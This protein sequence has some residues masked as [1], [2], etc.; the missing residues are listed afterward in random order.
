MN[1]TADRD[2]HLIVRYLDGN[3]TEEETA[4]LLDWLKA[5]QDNM[6]LYTTIRDIWETTGVNKEKD[7]EAKLALFELRK[8]ELPGSIKAGKLRWLRN[9]MLW[10]IA[11]SIV[12][13]LSTSFLMNLLYLSLKND[14]QI[15][16][17]EAI[18]PLGQKGQL[19]LADGTKVWLNSGSTLRYPTDFSEGKR[20]VYLQGEAYFDVTHK[21][22][23]PFMVHTGNIL[24]K[25]L[26]TS[27]NVKS[28][29]GEDKVE[30]TLIKG[31]VKLYCNKDKAKK[32]IA[33][34][35]PNQQATFDKESK[36]T[37]VVALNYEKSNKPDRV[38]S[39]RK[40]SNE[41][42]GL[43]PV[44]PHIES[45]IQWKD[46]KLVFENET[47]AD[48]V[49]RLERWYGKTLII[50]DESLKQDRYSGKFEYNESIYQV[51]DV[52]CHSSPDLLYFE[53]DHIL[54]IHSK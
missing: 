21:V 34:L 29:P 7:I 50:E 51:L 10:R 46:Q 33:T 42:S 17:N 25:V 20:N 52:I 19:I 2:Y 9:R 23:N 41:F 5:N 6:H 47:L 37:E 24:V 8:R 4:Q 1:F 53:K 28:Y 31:S 3:T 40:P 35:K 14:A 13:V 15:V 43:K 44:K 11:A 26:G 32:L 22:G 39:R 45:V 48:M 27:F 30:T 38:I 54:Y 12:I 18:I 36:K 49:V 16:F